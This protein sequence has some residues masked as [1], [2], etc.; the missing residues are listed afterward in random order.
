MFSRISE[1]ENHSAPFFSL[2][3]NPLLSV[4]GFQRCEPLGMLLEVPA[5]RATVSRAGLGQDVQASPWPGW[6]RDRPGSKG[7]LGNQTGN[8]LSPAFLHHVSPSVNACVPYVARNATR[9][10]RLSFIPPTILHSFIMS[11]INFLLKINSAIPFKFCIYTT[12]KHLR[13]FFIPLTCQV[14]GAGVRHVAVELQAEEMS[15][16]SDN[17][18]VL[19]ALSIDHWGNC[20]SN[21]KKPF[22]DDLLL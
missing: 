17:A 13:A 7:T 12:S 22:C 21:T 5:M 2:L 3:P 20:S 6:G 16:F 9:I 18:A 14:S 15:S 8:G 1:D 10:S 11:F 4:T 19:T